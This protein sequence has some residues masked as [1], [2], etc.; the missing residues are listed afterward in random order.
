L[1]LSLKVDG[2]QNAH[3]RLAVTLRIIGSGAVLK[4]LRDVPMIRVNPFGDA[5]AT[6]RL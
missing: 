6:Q 4:V 5:D 1:D 2:R 3:H